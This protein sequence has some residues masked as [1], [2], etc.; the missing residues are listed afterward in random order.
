MATVAL[1]AL[2]ALGQQPDPKPGDVLWTKHEDGKPTVVAADQGYLDRF[3]ELVRAKD[4]DAAQSMIRH[5]QCSALKRSD[6]VR[7]IQV[8]ITYPTATA[9]IRFLSG[10]NRGR[11]AWVATADLQTK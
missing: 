1:L 8:D 2:M 7:V 11:L 10:P 4:T 6:Q 3:Y 9:E 5:R